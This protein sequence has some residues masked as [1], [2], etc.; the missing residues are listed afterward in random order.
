M[1]CVAL[2][3]VY[4][5]RSDVAW[6][7]VLC[8]VLLR[9]VLYLFVLY[10][11]SCIIMLWF[12]FFFTFAFIIALL[13]LVLFVLSFHGRRLRRF[14]VLPY[15][16]PPPPINPPPPPPPFLFS[17]ILPIC[18]QH[19]CFL[20]QEEPE[21]GD[22]NI[23]T[24]T[25]STKYKK[26][27]E[28]SC[29]NKVDRTSLLILPEGEPRT[30]LGRQQGCEYQA[31]PNNKWSGKNGQHLTKWSGNSTK[32]RRPR[33]RSATE[34]KWKHYNHQHKRQ[35]N[36]SQ[37]KSQSNTERRWGHH[38]HDHHHHLYFHHH[39][40][41]HYHHGRQAPAKGTEEQERLCLLFPL[42][43]AWV[44]FYLRLLCICCWSWLWFVV[45][46]CFCTVFCLLF[47]DL[48]W[49]A[50]VEQQTRYVE[51]PEQTGDT[52]MRQKKRQDKM[53]QS[54]ETG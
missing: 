33:T 11:S 3:L 22:G 34:R 54:D 24:T 7:I 32:T 50:N 37:S 28:E 8:V 27:K 14:P 1:C 21:T 26:A 10:Y 30:C 23:T 40:R 5:F 41:H 53:N 44:C 15:T 51:E 9:I 4:M 48:K 43:F 12:S 45:L 25:R 46:L 20:T 35:K 6:S 31:S 52:W 2:C 19:I 47:I 17:L 13:V 36:T 42:N 18:F 49:L 38:H 39:R 29:Q 16:I